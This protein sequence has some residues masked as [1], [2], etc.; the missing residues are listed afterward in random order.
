ME[1]FRK[2]T[3]S[4]KQLQKMLIWTKVRYRRNSHPGFPRC[5]RERVFKACGI[6]PGGRC[7]NGDENERGKIN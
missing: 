3:K 6:F 4:F 7:G 5:E 2:F 1:A